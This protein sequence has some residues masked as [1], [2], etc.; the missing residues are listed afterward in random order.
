MLND[1]DLSWPKRVPSTKILAVCITELLIN[2][3]YTIEIK[4]IKVS[5]S[6][7][8]STFFLLFYIQN[9]SR[10]RTLAI[11]ES[12]FLNR[13]HGDGDAYQW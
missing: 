4:I 13:K 10:S 3:D 6:I 9:S 11:S 12:G 1:I 2:Y 7:N 8:N 5:W